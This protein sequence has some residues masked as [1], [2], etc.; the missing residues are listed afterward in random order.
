MQHLKG[1]VYINIV[2]S[3]GVAVLVVI[4]TLPTSRRSLPLDVHE[5]HLSAAANLAAVLRPRALPYCTVG[6]AVDLD[7]PLF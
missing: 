2:R 3:A 1:N 7:Y 5:K 4:M 6:H